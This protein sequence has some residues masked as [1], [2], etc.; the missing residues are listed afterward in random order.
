[1]R[2]GGGCRLAMTSAVGYGL[3]PA[4]DCAVVLGVQGFVAKS[5]RS[6]F[7]LAAQRTTR[8]TLLGRLRAI[9]AIALARHA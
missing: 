2:G 5:A 4:R 8:L 6:R 3:R 1:M 7:V 9:G